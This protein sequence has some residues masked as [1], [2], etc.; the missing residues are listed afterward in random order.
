MSD[1]KRITMF[2]ADWCGDCRRAKAVLDREQ[3]DYDY[4]DTEAIVDA[5]DRARAISGRMNIP[6]I[7]F[8]DGSHLVEPS[9]SELLAKLAA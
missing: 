8:P 7:V 3:I 5:A 9:D 4:I 1:T 2:G 6:V